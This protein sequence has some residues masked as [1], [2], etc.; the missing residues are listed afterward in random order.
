MRQVRSATID[1]FCAR[2]GIEPDF[3]KI[4]VEGWELAVLRGARDTIRSRG[5][6]LAL[7]VELHPSIWPALNLS[8]RDFEAELAAQNLQL[9]PL[10]SGEDPWSVE[11]VAVRLTH[12]AGA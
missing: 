6:S 10:T 2:E 5:A 7:F 12:A 11:G 1:R 9:A 3:I 8:R 4:D